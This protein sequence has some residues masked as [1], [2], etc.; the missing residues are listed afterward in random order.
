MGIIFITLPAYS[1]TFTHHYWKES[2]GYCPVLIFAL[3]AALFAIASSILTRLYSSVKED[4]GFKEIRI[5]FYFLFFSVAAILA[6]SAWPRLA[7]PVF[8]IILLLEALGFM[9][10]GFIKN[11]EGIFRLS[12][13]IFFLD[14]LSRY[15][16]IF[17]RMMPRSLLFIFGGIILIS[18]SVFAENQRKKMKEK[19]SGN[20]EGQTS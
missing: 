12:I 18:G 9:Y 11:S 17:W 15:F 19:I 10:L 5:A 20:S 13:A 7:S 3:I 8:N 16:D 14:I 4:S 6:S 1:L 2:K